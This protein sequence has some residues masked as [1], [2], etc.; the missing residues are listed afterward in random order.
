MAKDNIKLAIS[1]TACSWLA[2]V[3]D[4]SVHPSSTSYM[5]YY[6]YA[7]GM[8]Y[9]PFAKAGLHDSTGE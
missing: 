9:P 4:L 3:I 7:P 1:R 5:S 6:R 2:P 8:G